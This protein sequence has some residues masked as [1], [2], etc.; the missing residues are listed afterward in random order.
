M[1]DTAKALGLGSTFEFD[2]VKYRLGAMDG[3][4]MAVFEQWLEG[5]AREA[6]KR[7]Q[8]KTPPDEYQE[9]QSALNAD[10]AAGVYSFGSRVC[11]KALAN[12][13]GQKQMIFLLLKR[14]KQDDPETLIDHALVDRIYEKAFSEVMALIEA[15]NSD[16]NSP[17]PAAPGNTSLT[18]PSAPSSPASPTA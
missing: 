5:R 10:I 8:R 12:T 2:G 9:L 14:G 1:G 11:A 3:E 13:P 18:A 4:V 17:A 7:S 15:D 6:L 16:P